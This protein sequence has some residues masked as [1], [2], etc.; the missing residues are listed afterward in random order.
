MSIKNTYFVNDIIDRLR[1]AYN[2]STDAELADFLEVGASTISAWKRR[3]TID[4]KLIFT[5]C[6]ELR[7]DYI[8][9]GDKPMFR[10]KNDPANT[11]RPVAQDDQ[12]QY[13]PSDLKDKAAQFV[14]I[15]ENLPW[16]VETRREILQ[17]YLR[18]VDEE[19]RFLKK[20]EKSDPTE[21]H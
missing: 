2:M 10:D 14:Q 4:F 20:R 16:P 21:D 19:L 5:K 13:D 7:A 8:I 15:I 1:N 17:S 6:K 18:I 9:Y 11:A 3:N 12:A